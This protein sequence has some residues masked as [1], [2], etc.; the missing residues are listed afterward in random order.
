M[1]KP[2]RILLQTAIPTTEDGWHAGRFSLLRDHLASLSYSAGR[3]I[4]EVTAR[5]R[6]ANSDGGD[7][8]LSRLDATDFDEL[9]LLAV[10]AGDGL[11]E[12][13]R[14]G[15]TRFRRRGGGLAGGGQSRIPAADRDVAGDVADD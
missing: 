1:Y 5:D 8:I 15:I 4:C 14:R 7:A 11:T 6:G 12:A 13:D 3:L 2:I 10:D 9:W